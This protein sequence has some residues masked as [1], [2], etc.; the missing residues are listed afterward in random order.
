MFFIARNSWNMY[1][2]LDN[3]WTILIRS[4]YKLNGI[5]SVELIKQ[6]FFNTHIP[7]SGV[8]NYSAIVINMFK[9]LMTHASLLNWMSLLRNIT[10]FKHK[11]GLD[12][13]SLFI[14]R[15]SFSIDS[16]NLMLNYSIEKKNMI[17]YI[18]EESIEI[19]SICKAI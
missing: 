3:R 2:Y 18:F 9:M 6:S 8:Y 16:V 13:L 12:A 7:F 1:E 19:L 17:I 15:V 5:V 10:P 14:E 4:I 11:F